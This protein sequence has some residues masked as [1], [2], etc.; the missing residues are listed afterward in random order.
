MESVYNGLID[1]I[2]VTDDRDIPN[3]LFKKIK[4]YIKEKVEEKINVSYGVYETNYKQ[5]YCYCVKYSSV[6]QLYINELDDQ[7]IG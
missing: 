5:K 1:T 4:N 3:T 7:D 6:V 2:I